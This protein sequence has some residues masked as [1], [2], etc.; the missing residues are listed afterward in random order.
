MVT[1]GIVFVVAGFGF[2]VSA[3]PFHTWAPDVYQGAPTPVTAFLSVASKAAGFVALLALV[4]VGFYGRPEVWEPLVW[5]LAAVSMTVGNLIALRQTNIVRMMAYS[6][7][8]QTGFMIAPLA[9]AGHSTALGDQALSATVTY[10]AIYAAM[11]LG[12][13]AVIIS[14]A[15]RTG[16]AEMSSFAGAFRYAPAMTVAMTIF[17]GSL[18]GIPPLGGWF[19]K[20]EVFRVLT[21]SGDT[22]GYALA[23]VAAVNAVI[24]L[25]YYAS[26]LLRMWADE[27]P[28]EGVADVALTPSL[29]S[30]LVICGGVTLV[31]G[32]LPQVVAR[33]TDVSLLALGG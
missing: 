10:L 14:L 8:A 33:F 9:V 4:F 13:F 23:V 2:K 17:L 22:W 18:A 31:F 16:S 21:S 29:L 7:V 1:L 24:A 25:Y 19:A 26:V 6:G 32:V 20:F 3:A 12:A 28:D 30:A 27:A 15:R 5:T 11:N